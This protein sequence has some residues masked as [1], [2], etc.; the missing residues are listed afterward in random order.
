VTLVAPSLPGRTFLGWSGDSGCASN[1]PSVTLE[2][3]T[4]S[5]SCNATFAARYTVTTRAVPAAGG[6]VTATSGSRNAACSGARCEVDEGSNV[7]LNAVAN[8]S[9]RFTG[10]SGG[11]PCTGS[12]ARLDLTAVKASVTC[13]ANFVARIKVGGDVRPSNG[14]TVT[15]QQLSLSAQCAGP[16]CTVDA[17]SDVLL[18]ATPATGY[19]FSTWAGCGSSF[20]PLLGSNP[21]PVIGPTTDT[22]CTATFVKKTFLVSAVAGANGS[23]SASTNTGGCANAM[24]TVEYGGS[25][26]LAASPSTGYTFA[27]WS[28]CNIS[29]SGT[30]GNVTMAQTCTASFTKVTY[31][32]TALAGAGGNVAASTGGG[33]CGGARCTV[34][35]GGSVQLTATPATGYEFGGWSG[36]PVGAGGTVSNIQMPLTCT[37]S[38]T[39]ERFVLSGESSGPAADIRASSSSANSSCSG[40]AC[41]ADYGSSVTLTVVT[42]PAGYRLGG[43]EA[44]EGGRATGNTLTVD[45]L[46]STHVCRATFIR[47]WAVVGLSSEAGIGR[48]TVTSCSLVPCVVDDGGSAELTTS[49]TGSNYL[50]QWTC[51]GVALDEAQVTAPTLSFSNIRQNITCTAVFSQYVGLVHG[52]AD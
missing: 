44:C 6:Q 31:L 5:K 33:T 8:P 39:R 21:L 32:V 28:G 25:A 12:A 42:P 18:T 3:V 9:Y 16:I 19:D 38:F 27:G 34:D 50:E 4:T 1:T 37:A 43:W 11:G 17:G 46:T 41:T 47:V 36:C 14:G 13:S 49:V 51:S 35:Q 20:N 23:V 24:C 2:A 30:V 40:N 26:V 48:G 29:A 45:S 52:P 7:T 22:T 10:W 15:A